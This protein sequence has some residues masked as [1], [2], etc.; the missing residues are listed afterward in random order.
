MTESDFSDE[1]DKAVII[2]K[3]QKAYVGWEENSFP[4]MLG[5]VIAGRVANRFDLG[6]TNGQEV[7]SIKPD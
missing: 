5:N 1:A 6:G 4:G 2:D 3:F 7:N